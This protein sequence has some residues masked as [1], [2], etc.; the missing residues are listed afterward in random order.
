LLYDT[1]VSYP[2]ERAQ[3]LIQMQYLLQLSSPTSEKSQNANFAKPQ[4]S[5]VKQDP[6]KTSVWNDKPHFLAGWRIMPLYT[7]FVRG[8]R[9]SALPSGPGGRK[10]AHGLR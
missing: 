4:F 1:E 9:R 8:E 7:Q 2:P 10:H 3:R 6:F 5:E